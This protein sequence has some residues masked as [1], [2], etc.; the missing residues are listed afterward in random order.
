MKYDFINFQDKLQKE[1]LS[2]YKKL[3][4]AEEIHSLAL[5]TDTG[6]M[7]VCMSVNTTHFLAENI[8]DDPDDS[9]YYTWVPD[10]WKYD[11]IDSNTLDE[12]SSS[13]SDYVLNNEF[14]FEVFVDTLISCCIDVLHYLEKYDSSIEDKI[15]RLFTISDY[16][17]SNE[18]LKWIKELNQDKI[19]DEYEKCLSEL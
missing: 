15:I 12:L 7:T 4:V 9:C 6:A 8:K 14:E 1:V 2:I 13:L 18:K 11:Y 10:A 19:A 16:D 17:D 3:S 5:Y